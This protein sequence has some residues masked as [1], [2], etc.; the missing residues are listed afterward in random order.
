MAA[1]ATPPTAPL[2][3]MGDP[4]RAASRCMRELYSR[5]MLSI[6]LPDPT[7]LGSQATHDNA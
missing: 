6:S 5:Q 7:R 3:R 4:V 1:R 2:L